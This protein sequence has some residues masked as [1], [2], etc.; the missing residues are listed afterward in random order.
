VR[1]E[2]S[3]RVKRDAK[4]A[5]TDD[6]GRLR[7]QCCGEI[8]SLVRYEY[9]HIT[10]CK[11]GGDASLENCQ[12]L[13][14]ACHK[15]KTGRGAARRASARRRERRRTRVRKPSRFPGSRNSKLKK[16]IGGA[17]VPR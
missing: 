4:K 2:F 11:D 7:C 15:A 1:T 13:C 6:A 10:E 8:L 16:K 9:D 5:A 14:T 3:E 17:V 12:I